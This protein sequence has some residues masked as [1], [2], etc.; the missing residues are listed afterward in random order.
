MWEVHHLTSAPWA[1][2]PSGPQNV[3]GVVPGHPTAAEGP[4]QEQPWV[5]LLTHMPTVNRETIGKGKD[6]LLSFQVSL[7]LHPLFSE[8]TYWNTSW[9]IE[10]AVMG[11]FFFVLFCLCKSLKVISSS[12]P[13]WISISSHWLPQAC[14]FTNNWVAVRVRRGA[15]GDGQRIKIMSLRNV[16]T[17]GKW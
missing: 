5:G 12:L 6:C 15:R 9:V 13:H 3:W 4:G 1:T 7:V 16:H 8:P 11:R 2:S 10:T 17:V 14:S